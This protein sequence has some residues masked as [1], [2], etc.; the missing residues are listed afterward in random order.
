MTTSVTHDA[1]K[2]EFSLSGADTAL[3]FQYVTVRNDYQV[4]WDKIAGGFSGNLVV[5]LHAPTGPLGTIKDPGAFGSG[6]RTAIRVAVDNDANTYT[7]TEDAV[8][9]S[10]SG[11]A[12]ATPAQILQRLV[13]TAPE[14]A[15]GQQQDVTVSVTF[16]GKE[17]ENFDSLP[18][19]NGRIG[20]P[21]PTNIVPVTA[22]DPNAVAI[23]VAGPALPPPPPPAPVPTP[24]PPAPVPQPPTPAANFSVH[25]GSTGQ[26]VTLEGAAYTGP[27]GGLQHELLLITPDNL[28]IT[29]AVPN[30]FIH[31]GSGTD[32]IDVSA[33]GGNNVLDGG[34]GSNFLVGGKGLDTFFVDARG[35]SS[36]TWSTVSGFHSG[37]AATLWGITPRDFALSWVDGQGAVGS[38]GLTLHA[39]G[40]GK[41]DASLTLAGFT[42]ADLSNGKLAT[43]FGNNGG[44]DYLYIHA[45]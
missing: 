6:P 35:A 12:A 4:T 37:D 25:Y 34:T 13:Y 23:H 33:I 19:V 24:E 16:N 22:T 42:T 39:S 21:T 15:A 11:G 32:A 9:G 7:Y 45:A 14:L 1:A 3:A 43:V 8:G 36:A 10:Q 26:N 2:S 40:A 31:T 27:V 17:I 44:G 30:S 29:A 20:Y 5:T 28:A 41:P 38:K 18:N